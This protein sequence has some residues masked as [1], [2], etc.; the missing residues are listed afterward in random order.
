PDGEPFTFDSDN[1]RCVSLPWYESTTFY[2]VWTIRPGQQH[3]TN[4]PQGGV[5][6]RTAAPAR[7]T[8]EGMPPGAA[9]TARQGV[10]RRPMG[11]GRVAGRSGLDGAVGG[12][13]RGRRNGPPGGDR[14]F[15]SPRS[16][17]GRSTPARP[18]HGTVRLLHGPNSPPRCRVGT[19]LYCEWLACQ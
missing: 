10:V 15:S 17:W 12:L 4:R 18:C 8:Q 1:E 19:I 14:A 11:P 13:R 5:E 6:I 7:H 16:L 9:A 2:P 3:E